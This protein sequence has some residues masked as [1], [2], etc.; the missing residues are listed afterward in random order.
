MDN[1]PPVSQPAPSPDRFLPPM[2]EQLRR[3]MAEA[4][5]LRTDMANGGQPPQEPAPS[6]PAPP[7]APGAPP[8]GDTTQPVSTP[9]AEDEQTL[10]QRLR[11]TQ[12]RLE[13]ATK[14]NQAM[15]DRLAQM[16]QQFAVM[17]VKG[18]E[19]FV[20][21]P[22][23][24]KPKLITDQEAE[25]YGE[26]FLTVVGK[27]AKEEYAPEFEQLAQRLKRLEG[28]VEGVGTV[29]EKNQTKD[30]YQN[31][32]EAVPNWRDINRSDQFKLWLQQPDPYAG[33]RRHDMLTEAFSRHEAN[34]VVTFFKGFLTEAA[35]LPQ[36]PQAK[37]PSAPPLPGN[38]N[39]SGKPSLA[40][41]AA[42]GRARS[43]PQQ[44]PPDKPVYTLAWIAKFMDDKR[45]GL[46]RGRE[47]D[48]DAIERD[49]Y[50]AQ[51]EG[52]IQ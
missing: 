32:A 1:Q 43:A 29:L 45:K 28:Q 8:P 40:D 14:N 39:G 4:D 7:P 16:E 23:P 13:Q 41:F 42:P 36:T 5:Q 33:R 9:P 30:I 47:T 44:L 22:A 21:A 11:S 37:D 20:P 48:A 15:A 19:P 46:Y 17:K 50:M 52:R 27:R 12:G 49:I 51:H 18:A 31:L 24:A 35:G 26:E 2:P 10:E 3:Q 6:E 38:G 34:R 25:E